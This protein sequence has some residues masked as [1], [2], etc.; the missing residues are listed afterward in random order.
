MTSTTAN[1]M[2][3]IKILFFAKLRDKMGLSEIDLAFD[4]AQPLAQLQET[5][6]TQYPQFGTLPKPVLVAIN[7][8]FADPAQ[9]VSPGDEVAFF[10]PVTGG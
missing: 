10:P 5:L 2:P 8:A 7:Q 1:T 9:I 4:H 6:T 3:S